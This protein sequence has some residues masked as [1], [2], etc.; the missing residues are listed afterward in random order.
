MQTEGIYNIADTFIIDRRRKWIRR[1][2]IIFFII[3]AVLI[4]AF[5][6]MFQDQFKSLASIKKID[7]YGMFQMTYFGD[8]KFDDF[9]KTGAK[10]D[11]E[12][13]I[14]IS[15]KLLK[16]FPVRFGINGRTCTAFVTRNE[17]G[18]VIYGRN[19]D[20]TYSP[21]LQVTT[22]PDNGYASVSTVN[23]S[24]VGYSLNK[25]PSGLNTNSVLT[26]AAP[27]IPFDGMNEKGV[28]ISLLAVPE[29]SHTP[30]INK[31]TLNTTTAIRLVLDKA[32]TVNEAV[33]LLRQYNIYFS[34][35]IACHYLIA[36]S[37]GQSVI[38]EYYNGELQ[39]I[40]TDE[41]CQAASNFI[42]YNGLN[43]GEGKDEFQRYQTT[44]QTIQNHNGILNNEQAVSLL[45][46]VGVINER[47]SDLLQWSVIYN[48]SSLSGIIFANRNTGNL[49]HFQL[50][51][52]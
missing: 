6:V 7:N 34:G 43:I 36:D 25:L 32:A 24:F 31:I 11:S 49:I 20:Y 33:A 5:S 18:D 17:N 46:R 27:F 3:S 50:E 52:Q 23:L 1:I 9:L 35:G 28:A 39:T 42:A 29:A 26:L 16:G 30:D 19:F 12:I 13:E 38:V 47:G 48:L 10:N 21:S 41:S 40:T 4:T 51:N 45:V 22:K 44:I 14:F 37:G 8:Y 2:L 15:R